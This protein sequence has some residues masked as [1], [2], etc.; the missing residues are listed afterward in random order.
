MGKYFYAILSKK[1]YSDDEELRF[2]PTLASARAA[3][4]HFIGNKEP[5]KYTCIA[6]YRA[7]A[8]FCFDEVFVGVGGRLRPYLE[9]EKLDA[10]FS[11]CRI[12]R[13]YQTDSRGRAVQSLDSILKKKRRHL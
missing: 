13:E 6:Q 5:L 2:Y 4:P 1:I 9:P 3:F 10:V 11:A 12:K 8:H 7:P